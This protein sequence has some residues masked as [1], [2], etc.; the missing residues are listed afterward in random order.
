M[1]IYEGGCHCGNI[2]VWFK[3]ELS[4]GHLKPRSCQCSFCRKHSTRALSDGNGQINLAIKSNALLNR[5]TFGIKSA[6][7]LICKRCG[8]YVSAYM[9]DGDKAYANVMA[10]TLRNHDAFPAGSPINYEIEDE[11]GKRERRRRTWSPATLTFDD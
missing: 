7:F 11:Q 4:P 2:Q 10:N 6:E 9:P 5:Y 1:S 8:V 3:T